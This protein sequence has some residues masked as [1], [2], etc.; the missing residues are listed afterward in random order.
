MDSYLDKL[1]AQLATGVSARRAIL[2]E[3]HDGLLESVQHHLDGE[4]TPPEAARAAVAE[5]GDPLEVSLA[6]APEIAALRARRIALLL[7]RT[8][9][10]VGL[11]WAAALIKSPAADPLVQRHELIGAW[12]AFPLIGIIILTIVTLALI[13]VALTGR[14]SR[15]LGARSTIT[16]TLA[17]SAG[18]AVVAGDLMMLGAVAVQMILDSTSLGWAQCVSQPPQALRDYCCVGAPLGDA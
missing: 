6:F 13:T 17:A 18:V 16:T 12:Q 15:H 7:L 3:L 14:F 9:P 1:D 4:R 8:G 5:F 10:L 2:E 11:L